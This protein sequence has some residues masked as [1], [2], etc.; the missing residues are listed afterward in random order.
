MVKYVVITI[1]FDMNL[2]AVSERIMKLLPS[3]LMLNLMMM[4]NHLDLDGG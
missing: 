4:M 2:I 1:Q 3:N